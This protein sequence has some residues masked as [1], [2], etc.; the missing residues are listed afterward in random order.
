MNK[1]K[2]IT[3]SGVNKFIDSLDKGRQAR[4]DRI[5]F[6]FEEYGPFL[7]GKYLKKLIRDVWELRPGDVRLF[8]HIKRARERREKI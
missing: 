5:Y 7:P 3:F 8:L 1:F 4:V 2:I 6:L